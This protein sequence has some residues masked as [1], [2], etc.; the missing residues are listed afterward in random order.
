MRY[1]NTIRLRTHAKSA[2]E[3]DSLLTSLKTL[4]AV[5]S[6]DYSQEVLSHE[7]FD[8][9]HVLIIRL[10]TQPLQKAFL[11]FLREGLSS[12]EKES[13]SVKP[14][15][16]RFCLQ[17]LLDKSSLLA[18]KAVLGSSSVVSVRLNLCAHPKNLLSAQ[19]TQRLLFP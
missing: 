16:A 8:T 10:Y 4:F 14:L 3:N 13:L 1:T 7:S 19:R 11:S 6:L 5:S 18:G 15:D 12:Q 9:I 17:F 2:E